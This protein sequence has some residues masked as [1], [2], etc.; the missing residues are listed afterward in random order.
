MEGYGDLLAARRARDGPIVRNGIARF[1]LQAESS[2]C[3]IEFL[4]GLDAPG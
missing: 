1:R 2:G 3:G 4:A